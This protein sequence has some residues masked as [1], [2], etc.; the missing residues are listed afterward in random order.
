MC[1]DDI[2]KI[3]LILERGILEIMNWL[4]YH[5]EKNNMIKEINRKNGNF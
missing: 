3:D 2:T 5:Q 4:S 1:N